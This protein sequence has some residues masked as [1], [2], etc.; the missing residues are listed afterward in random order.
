M[1]FS[2]LSFKNNLTAKNLF[3]N[4][5]AVFI[6]LFM[7]G[8]LFA[9]ELIKQ[10]D[11]IK[12]SPA[13]A[14]ST[15]NVKFLSPSLSKTGQK[16]II[17]R[18][19]IEEI[20]QKVTPL[21]NRNKA[22]KINMAPAAP[23]RDILGDQRS[24]FV[25]NFQKNAYDSITATLRKVG[26]YCY[27]YV[28]NS[29]WTANLVTQIQIETIVSTFDN[30]YYPTEVAYFGQENSPGIDNDVKIT[31]LITRIYTSSSTNGTYVGYF[32]PTDELPDSQAQTQGL[33]SN[34]REM[35]YMNGYDYIPANPTF[36]HTL[37]H[38]FQHM[39]HYNQN[40]SEES[41]VNEGM[42]DLAA[43]ITGNR[44]LQDKIDAFT[45]SS[46]TTSLIPFNQTIANYGASFLFMI[47][48]FEQYG[49]T[50]DYEKQNFTRNLCH[51]GD[52]GTRTIEF[53]LAAAG[54]PDVKFK[55]VFLDWV[56]TNYINSKGFAKFKYKDF[57]INIDPLQT[58]TGYPVKDR[59][60]SVNYW[61]A[62]YILLKYAAA[63]SHV[64][65]FSGAQYGT[66]SPRLC[67]FNKD[68]TIVVKNIPLNGDN[69]GFYDLSDFG[70]TY[71]SVL[72]VP[73]FVAD[74]G[75]T[76]YHYAVG[77]AGPKVGIYP[78]PI[79]NDDMYITVKSATK[80]EVIVKRSGG[81]DEK[82][83][84]N[85]AQKGLYSGT[86]H[87]VYSGIFEVSVT[88]ED[89]NGL[90]GTIKTQFEIRKLQNKVLNSIAFNGRSY[91]SAKL[92]S[93]SDLST[94]PQVT[95]MPIKAC[96]DETAILIQTTDSELKYVSGVKTFNN[97]PRSISKNMEVNFAYSDVVTSDTAIS[98]L[99]VYELDESSGTFKYCDTVVKN[100]EF[101][102]AAINGAGTYCLMADCTPP[103]ISG[104]KNYSGIIDMTLTD[105]G[106]GINRSAINIVS[107]S[108]V[109]YTYFE[110]E[111][112]L[113]L[114]PSS[115]AKAI[116]VKVEDNAKNS[117]SYNVNYQNG[118]LTAGLSSLYAAPNPASNFAI[119]TWQGGTAPYK[120]DI[121]DINSNIISNFEGINA[122]SFRW[123]LLKN[124]LSP[125]GN[126]VYYF[127]VEDN[128][129]VKARY[130]KIAVLK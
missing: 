18:Q 51:S 46:V 118:N 78:N 43:Y 130:G 107:D 67:F 48:L 6:V 56:M 122:R 87:I 59:V 124:D 41:W 65:E 29:L 129:G 89:D 72:M 119:I 13:P 127:S 108:K 17:G 31:I 7:S 90:Q 83:K 73:A 94:D 110:N 91:L 113:R 5:T 9:G 1:N 86:Y 21:I 109:D 55:D 84:M 23:L 128:N 125:A 30:N 68:G 112:I 101:I 22:A 123:N 114:T 50:S 116:T 74:R 106:S 39:I 44:I 26:A 105:K 15:G 14:A 80:P 126:G 63:S 97:I 61:T 121:Y 19:D 53:A 10:D 64:L 54:Y 81:A 32:D 77:F 20:K 4:I 27:V 37:A 35:F 57:V 2:L 25:F 11:G 102:T 34:Q 70:T 71:N 42:S 76:S 95:V 98:Q 49:G 88:G 79:F 104:V 117:V 100:N 28:D 16:P 66:F 93:P 52:K 58:H 36:M 103:V 8:S 33:R 120:I 45:K 69:K 85:Y 60:F 3:L 115:D 12:Y 47:Y 111:G 82:V 92:E 38:E 24:F 40:P 62:N 75:P 99:G 96:E